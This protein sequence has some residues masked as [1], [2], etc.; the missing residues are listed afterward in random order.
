MVCDGVTS[1]GSREGVY[2]YIASK[3]RSSRPL[4]I[5]THSTCKALLNDSRQ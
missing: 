1:S 5:T 3:A 4:E 2:T